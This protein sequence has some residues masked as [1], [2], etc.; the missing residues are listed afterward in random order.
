MKTRT[1]F[2]APAIVALMG[3]ALAACSAS[4]TTVTS[5]P[6]G[7]G[8]GSTDPAGSSPASGGGQSA[9][10][11]VTIDFTGADSVQGSFTA[12]AFSSYTCAQMGN[13]WFVWFTGLGPNEGQPTTVSGKLINFLLSIPHSRFHGSGTYSDVMP[14]GVMVDGDNFEGSNSTI[15][16]NSD[17]TGNASFTNL[18]G[19]DNVAGMSESGTV[20]WTC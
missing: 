3:L 15:T 1:R 13:F 20:S 6:S 19:A 11:A 2:V 17:G 8:G 7:N 14:A 16:I 9:N 12:D 18:A 4:T 5:P 10:V